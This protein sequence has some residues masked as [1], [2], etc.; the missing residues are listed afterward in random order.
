MVKML[1]GGEQTDATAT[2]EL[3]GRWAPVVRDFGYRPAYVLQDG[4]EQ[5]PDDAEAATFTGAILFSMYSQG[6]YSRPY[7]K[8][9]KSVLARLIVAYAIAIPLMAIVFYFLPDVKIWRSSLVIA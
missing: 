3:W 9:N 1:I 7:V 2:D 4:C 6:L 5:L 8:D